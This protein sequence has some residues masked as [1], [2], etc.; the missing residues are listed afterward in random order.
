MG[1][2][3]DHIILSSEPSYLGRGLQ[4]CGNITGSRSSLLVK[5][6]NM[7][8]KNYSYQQEHIAQNTLSPSLLD[9]E[10]SLL[11]KGPNTDVGSSLIQA[12]TQDS[13]NND[14]V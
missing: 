8:D 7:E 6:S 13:G 2:L 5:R 11:G 14:S 3:Q 1:D 10:L 4:D 12:T 9:K